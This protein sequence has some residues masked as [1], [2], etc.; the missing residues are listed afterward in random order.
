MEVESTKIPDFGQ[1][2]PQDDRVTENFLVL[3]QAVPRGDPK[4][5]KILIP[6]QVSPVF[7]TSSP[8]ASS[9]VLRTET[10]SSSSCCASSEVCASS[11]PAGDRGQARVPP[12]ARISTATL[13]SELLTFLN[14]NIRGYVSNHAELCTVCELVAPTFVALTETFLHKGIK[15]L[16][17]IPGYALVSR[18]DRADN[19][20]WGGV[21]LFVKRG[22][23]DYIVHSASSTAA[24]R[25]WHI[26]HSDR[27]P[28]SVCVWYRPPNQG[29]VATIDS[30]DDELR[31]QGHGTLGSIILGDMN[32]HEETWLRFSHGTS[33]EGRALRDLC[34]ELG[35]EQ[36]VRKPTRG[37]Y[38]LDLVL[39]DLGSDVRTGIVPGIAD[40]EGVLVSLRF[41]MP[42]ISVV[43][44]EVFLYAKANWTEL[45]QAVRDTDWKTVLDL[46]DPE[47]SAERFTTRIMDLVRAHVPSKILSDEKSTHP[48]LTEHCKGLIARKRAAHGTDA[49]PALRD[50]CSRALTDAY[51]DFV[52]QTRKKLR[53][54]KR[55][56][57]EW[58]RLSRSLMSLSSSAEV[59]P[60]LKRQEGSWAKTPTEKAELLA[61]TFAK[62]AELDPCEDNS[63][64]AIPAPDGVS[65]GDGFVPIRQ[66]VTKRVLAKLD[67]NSGTGPDK[68]AARVLKKCQKELI[69]PITDLARILFARA[70]WPRTWRLHWVHPLY[71]KK[72]RSDPSN[73]RG[74][75]LTPQISKVVE[76]IVGQ[77]FLRWI[78]ANEKM[79]SHQYAY[80]E[81][82]S[83]KDALA[84][85]VTSWLDS[86]ENQEL[87]GLYCSDVSGA[88]D[89]VR[90]SRLVSKLRRSG[91]NPR[92][93]RFLES[94]LEDRSSVVIVG[95]SS[96]V[97]APLCNTVFQGTVL[98]SPLWN[99]F[100]VDSSDAVRPKGFTDVVFA[101]D[102]NCFKPF[103]AGTSVH[104]ILSE[105]Q[106]CQTEL[107]G[108]GRANS[109]RFDASKES[110]HVLHRTNGH[111]EDFLLL[112]IL[113]DVELRMGIAVT[114]LAR[115]A[116]WRLKT[117]LRPRRFFTERETV[118]LYK[119]QV[120]SYLE[121]GTPAYAHAARSVLDQL[122]RVQRRLL[123]ELGLCAEEALEKYN[124]APLETRRDIAMLAVLHK[125]VLGLAPPQL[126]ALFPKA[127]PL[128]RG[129]IPTRL[130]V[131]RHEHQLLLR[132]FRT[133]VLKRSL[134]GMVAVYNLLPSDV[135]AAKTVPAFQRLLQK[136]V[137]AAA[138][139]GVETWQRLLSPE[140]RVLRPKAFQT[141]FK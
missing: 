132:A 125:V 62:K 96:S 3:D 117:V 51:N 63:Y 55:S 127:P 60:P 90:R 47:G 107:H 88:F 39:S 16:L 57:R 35:L 113:F 93:V 85:N 105:C 137:K 45:R 108:W 48:W 97:P 42:E 65:M 24:E 75:H 134:F 114:T 110:F 92:I 76:R 115:E 74:V 86:L 32:V 49:F 6:G 14:L 67:P 89:R 61:E 34:S 69:G 133:D 104:N 40:H 129:R 59:I 122:D 112:G 38:L 68:L 64:S 83:H 1:A 5:E 121:S 21:V 33:V 7:V 102:F 130:L 131:R 109:V 116:G 27:G 84:I 91:L 139:Q 54:L 87:V 79:G 50:E 101:D 135:V 9:S 12:T 72:A 71:K 8:E 78:S 29:E 30:L 99:L 128:E 53:T 22:F 41:Q 123:R 124:L 140:A 95:G 43:E 94:W 56:S 13:T 70:C 18:L 98:G 100:Y 119:S 26:L 118:N 81:K 2:V 73:Y 82:R 15:Q 120:L 44:R 10:S 111:G 126:A 80:T 106:G 136:G 19:T 31:T 141:L 25:T 66:R 20:G 11:P 58:W 23:E 52:Q 103:P 17:P 36:H 28:L 77:T 4:M 46:E 37:E 138:A